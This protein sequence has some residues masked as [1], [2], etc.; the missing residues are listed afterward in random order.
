[1]AWY[2]TIG[3][4]ADTV[5]STRV[6]LA[7]NL[8]GHKFPARMDTAE[9]NELIE[10]FSPCMERSGMRKIHFSEISAVMATSYAERHYIDPA[11]I[12]SELPRALFLQESD[13]IAVTVGA[14]DHLRIRCVLP[15]LALTEAYRA[16]FETEHR[17]DSEFDFA[18]EETLGYLTQSPADLG[19]GMRVTALL[20]LPALTKKR[21][22]NALAEQLTQ[23][24]FSVL[25]MFG[26][27]I[28]GTGALYQISNRITLGISE[29]EILQRFHRTIVQ[30]S[31]FE[32]TMRQTIIEEAKDVLMDQ[33]QRSVGI[34]KHAHLLSVRELIRFSSD[35][36]FGISMGWISDLSYEQL[37]TLLTETMPATLTLSAENQPRSETAR[38]KLRAERVRSIFIPA[39]S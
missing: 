20:F 36:R 10:Q 18:Y 14:E 33:V 37:N 24:G 13:G 12:G 15:G 31:E 1:M 8:I 4:S 21:C 28:G 6:R 9:A 38:D 35:V 25:G 22:M 16:V 30:I 34:L 32:R 19:T 39:A 29:N 3:A 5:I 7:R 26:E 17:L 11:F 2:H 27:G 23:S